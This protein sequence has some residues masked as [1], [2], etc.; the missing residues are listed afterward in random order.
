MIGIDITQISRISRLRE[1][2]GEQFLKRILNENEIKLIKSDNS[3]AGFYAAKEAFS[4]ALGVGIGEEFS[5][6]DIEI[7]KTSKNA[8]FIIADNKIIEKFGIKNTS[9]SI[10]HDGGFAIAAVIIETY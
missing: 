9:L 8:P 5:F 1:R 7:S 3:L 2:Y 10:S 6:L 4:K